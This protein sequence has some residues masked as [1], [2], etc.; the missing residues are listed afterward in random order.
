MTA[1]RQRARPRVGELRP[2]QLLQTFG[3]GS[4]VDLPHLSVMVMGLDDWNTGFTEAVTEERL[5]AAVR[6]HLGQPGGRPAD[7]AVPARDRPTRSTSGPRSACRW[8]RS[9]AGC[10]V[11]AATC[12][13]RSPAACS[14][15][16]PS[17]SA[18]TGPAMSTPTARARARRPTCS[19]PASCW[20]ASRSPRRLPVGGVRPPGGEL[21][22]SGAGAARDRGQ[23]AGGRR[24]GALPHLQH[25]PPDGP[26]VR[27]GG[28]GAA[29]PLPWPPS[30]PG[31]VRHRLRPAGPDD[32]AGRL[33]RLV[34]GA[35]ERPVDPRGRRTARPE[36]R[37][38]L[39]RPAA[40]HQPRGARLR[41]WRAEVRDLR[42]LHRRRAVGGHR[43]PPLGRTARRPATRPTCWARSGRRSA[44][45]PALRPA[46]TSGSAPRRRR[47]ASPAASSRSSWPS[48]CGRSR[49]WSGSPASTPPTSRAT[50]P[51]GCGRRWPATDRC[52]CRA[53]RSAARA[54]S[55]G[56][57]SSRWPSGSGGSRAA[58]ARIA[59]AEASARWRHARGLPPAPWPGVRFTLLHT[60]AH[61]LIREFAL[62]C[63]YGAAGLA[64]RLYAEETD[65]G[66]MAGLL[67]YTAAP[68]S[69]G[70]LGGL[71]E[72]GDP[73]PARPAAR[74]GARPRAAVQLRPAVCRTR[75]RRGR[76]PARRRL[77]CLPV[78]GRDVLSGR[79]PLPGP[80]TAGRHPRPRR[81]GVLRP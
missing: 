27:G 71:V 78:R 72:L 21:L 52:G 64:E 54:S 28:Q 49:R 57:P 9:R 6:H 39:G 2:S 43:G 7:P 73:R 68:D 24:P 31:V 19:P 1:T 55:S 76:L 59:F 62:E 74:P 34:R 23:R 5:L 46:T 11:P 14:P 58:T 13:R 35:A 10:A 40:H 44:T 61:V 15:S 12:W 48:A 77:P 8:R 37:R 33:Q 67:L 69:E 63:G 18:R 29:A 26:G 79:Q 56:W 60:L 80:V 75:T 53:P 47:P 51:S 4:V 16:R 65:Q 81:P 36:G 41:P 30:A 66:P 45:R 20:P 50:A 32:P 25:A 17:W 38:A 3:V 22:R 42:R 70:T